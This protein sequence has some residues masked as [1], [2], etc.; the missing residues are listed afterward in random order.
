[1]IKVLKSATAMTRFV[2]AVVFTAMLQTNGLAQNGRTLIAGKV[3]D[4]NHVP[5]AYAT[6]QLIKLNDPHLTRNVQSDS[7]GRFTFKSDSGS[8]L[9]K[10][11]TIGY[12]PY[13]SAYFMVAE[14]DSIQIPTVT[15]ATIKSMLNGV[16][17]IGKKPFLE[18]RNDKLI[19]N[20]GSSITS[21]GAT[22]LEILR[23]VPGVIVI[24]DRISL[25]GKTSVIIMIDGKPSPYTDLEGLLKDMPGGNIDQ[26]EV[27]RNPGAKYEA[28]GSAGIIN[29]IMKRRSSQGL[30]GSYSLSTGYSYYD[31][32]AARSNDHTY[33]RINP[34]FSLNYSADRLVAYGSVDYLNRHVFEVNNLDRV[35]E[36]TRYEQENYYPYHYDIV[37]YRTGFDYTLSSKSTAGLLI[38]GNYRNGSGTSKTYTKMKDYYSGSALD[39]FVTDNLTKIKRQNI[40]FNLHYKLLID[41][42]G[43]TLSVDA[44]YSDYRYRN[45][46]L[47]DILTAGADVHNNQL[48]RN[49]LNYTTFKGDYTYPFNKSLR[50]DA[51][52]KFS[53][54]NIDNDLLFTRNGKVDTIQSNRFNYRETVKAAYLNLNQK[55]KGFEY[56]VGLR[57]EHTSTNGQVAA[58]KVVARKYLQ[59]FPSLS[60]SQKLNDD[61]SVYGAY[62]RRIDRP[63]F[64]FLSPF[65]Y[66]IDSLTYSKGNPAL[67]PQ[68]TNAARISFNFKRNYFFAISYN[69]T[70]NTIYEAAPEQVGAVT[71][72]QA[73]NLGTFKTLVAELNTPFKL[74]DA[75]GGNANIQEIYSYYNTGYM[76]TIY[77]RGKFNFQGNA[78]VYV[79]LS[80]TLT[81]EANAY[82]TSGT[83]HEFNLVSAFSG[84]NLGLQK[85]VLQNKG[86][87]A[88]S[89]ND[90]FY[91]NPT[92]SII[93]YQN[94]HTRY[95]YRDESRNFRLAFTYSFGNMQPNRRSNK[96]IGSKEEN[97]RL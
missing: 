49:P 55:Y 13:R 78:N 76:S 79:K 9:I 53:H 7:A 60:F 46:A 82:Y 41:T 12:E 43:Q 56:Q 71:Y 39:S 19:V 86:K 77:Q 67:L 37:N 29:I 45:H 33:Y 97:N 54:V 59:L 91:R 66:F 3:R 30:T 83:I 52:L 87:I 51:G 72:T 93:D 16:T 94:I 14:Q 96:D 70:T 61:W 63:Q 90:I 20:V 36:N 48:G 80:S 89:A 69:H 81:A 58:S 18:Q 23:K 32:S 47:I 35:I 85:S 84:I 42:S 50:L 64:V 2:L 31:Q 74:S 68:I 22:G 34:A 57:A 17:I 28:A 38:T 24:N 25:S 21:A 27:I 11:A 5:V 6:V 26:I 15:L 88:F 40:T 75:V 73:N 92:L 95:Y 44:D 8:Y 10:V 1:M 62:S 65:S 4:D